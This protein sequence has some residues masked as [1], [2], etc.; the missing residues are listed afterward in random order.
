MFFNNSKCPEC[1]EYKMRDDEFRPYVSSSGPRETEEK[2]N[3]RKV[4]QTFVR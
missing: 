4:M 1:F 3:E 2:K